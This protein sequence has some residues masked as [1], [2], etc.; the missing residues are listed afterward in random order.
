MTGV[1]K[2]RFLRKN[3]LWKSL[4]A[5]PN[6]QNDGHLPQSYFFFLF[7]FYAAYLCFLLLSLEC[8][9]ASPVEYLFVDPAR[10]KIRHLA[11]IVDLCAHTEYKYW[12][13]ST[14]IFYHPTRLC[15][16]YI[17]VSSCCCWIPLGWVHP[18]TNRTIYH[19]LTDI[20]YLYTSSTHL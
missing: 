14:T 20:I 12:A 5:L 16:I 2:L 18:F 9:R 7:F 4:Y 13:F 15:N 1:R 11:T 10:E 8:G 6:G 19:I 3:K 17:M